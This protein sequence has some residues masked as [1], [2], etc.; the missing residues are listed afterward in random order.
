MLCSL[1]AGVQHKLKAAATEL[2]HEATQR[3]GTILDFVDGR[4]ETSPRPDFSS[5]I[6]TE[7]ESFI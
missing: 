5:D 4:N 7:P 6:T 1:Q 3:Q 2:P